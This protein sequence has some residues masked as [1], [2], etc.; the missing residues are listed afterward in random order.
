MTSDD[1]TAPDAYAEHPEESA[2][3]GAGE[4]VSDEDRQRA[5]DAE[6]A[7]NATVG[8]T[9]DT[10]DVDSSAHESGPGSEEVAEQAEGDPS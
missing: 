9:V 4:R 3:P 7:G 5:L 2:F 8:D 1:Q 10:D 6:P